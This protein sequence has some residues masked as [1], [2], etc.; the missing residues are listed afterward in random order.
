MSSGRFSWWLA[1]RQNECTHSLT[2]RDNGYAYV[3]ERCFD[4]DR[5]RIVGV[6]EPGIF[7]G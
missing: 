3:W 4:C 2:S 7:K 6:L 1:A 5:I